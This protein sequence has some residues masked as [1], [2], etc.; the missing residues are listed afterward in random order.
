MVK[1]KK[2]RKKNEENERV[3]KERNEKVK[4]SGKKNKEIDDTGNMK[5]KNDE[6]CS[7]CKKVFEEEDEEKCIGCDFCDGWL[8][9]ECTELDERTL[10][11]LKDTPFKNSILNE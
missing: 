6:I 4:E 8:H 11:F 1:E 9:L 5:D 7:R 10:S 3:K 2:N